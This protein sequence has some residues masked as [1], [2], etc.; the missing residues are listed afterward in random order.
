MKDIVTYGSNISSTG[1]LENELRHVDFKDKR[2][3]NRL[4]KTSNLLD[5]KASGTINQS[6]R[7]WK[8]AKGAYRLF[9]NDKFDID[10]VYSSHY[11]E[12]QNRIQGK[13]LVF[14]IQDTTY[15]DMTLILKQKN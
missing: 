6:C 12:T 3:I 14:A 4:I 9:S 13:N 8:D 7:S 15:L 5:S 10:E 2:L 11:V 1:W